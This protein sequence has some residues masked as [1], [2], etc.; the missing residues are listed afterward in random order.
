MI[1]QQIFPELTRV[2]GEES[3]RR[4]EHLKATVLDV[5]VESHATVLEDVVSM[6]GTLNDKQR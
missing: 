3:E 4:L 2:S 1:V 5:G 6:R